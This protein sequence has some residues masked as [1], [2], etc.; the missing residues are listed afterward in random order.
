MV[1]TINKENKRE[2]ILLRIEKLENSKNIKTKEFNLA[3]KKINNQ[4]NNFKTQLEE[5]NNSKTLTNKERQKIEP[6]IYCCVCRKTF[7]GINLED[8]KK[9]LT[10]SPTQAFDT[11]YHKHRA[12]CSNTCNSCGKV[13]KSH[14]G[15]KLHK[16]TENNKQDFSPSPSPQPI[17][18]EI[19]EVEE[20]SDEV[21]ESSSDEEY[22]S[23]Q[24][25]YKN[26]YVGNKTKKVIDD[27]DEHIGYMYQN[28]LIHSDDDIYSDFLSDL[29][30]N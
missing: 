18:C 10:K 20:S 12:I 1:K 27:H 30:D 7:Y 24:Y 4:L 25:N 22:E 8:Y 5:L 19:S 11:D 3:I 28:R 13:F 21:E 17:K 2:S 16:C 29:E 9:L 14:M 6:F 26:Y 15:K 23:W